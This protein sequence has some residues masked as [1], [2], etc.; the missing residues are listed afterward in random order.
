VRSPAG[1]Y[2]RS[3]FYCDYTSW[4]S[5]N[6]RK[7]FSKGRVKELLEHN[8]G[9]GI[10]LVELNGH[11]TFR[12]VCEKPQSSTAK[13]NNTPRMS[14]MAHPPKKAK[15]ATWVPAKTD[16]TSVASNFIA[17]VREPESVTSLDPLPDHIQVAF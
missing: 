11:E 8:I 12:G 2:R 5:E 15:G 17:E 3:A 4:C 10:R 6:G 9:M 13:S 7:P 1:E 16:I 14:S